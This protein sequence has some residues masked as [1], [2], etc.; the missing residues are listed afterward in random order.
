MD[1]NDYMKTMQKPNMVLVAS[2]VSMFVGGVLCFISL[3]IDFPA[4]LYTLGFGL[5][6]VIVAIVCKLVLKKKDKPLKYKAKS[7]DKKEKKTRVV[8]ARKIDGDDKKVLVNCPK[9]G[10]TIRVKNIPGKHGVKCPMCDQ[11]FETI[12]K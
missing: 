3:F 6:L 9:C 11:Y 1:M 2:K 12:I 8:E 4:Y 10:R 5:A 7:K